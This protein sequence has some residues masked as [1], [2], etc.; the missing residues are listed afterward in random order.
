MMVSQVGKSAGRS[1]VDCSLEIGHMADRIV[2]DWGPVSRSGEVVDCKDQTC[3]IRSCLFSITTMM[4]V[5]DGVVVY[6]G[7]G[8]NLEVVRKTS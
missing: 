1:L 2:G 3:R 8:E 7:P 4:L 5:D 6:Q